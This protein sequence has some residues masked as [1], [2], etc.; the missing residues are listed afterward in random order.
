MWE[1][2]AFAGIAGVLPSLSA[3]GPLAV[4]EFVW[5]AG[6]AC[7]SVA[8]AWAL[9]TRALAALPLARAAIV[10]SAVRELQRLA[11]TALPSDVIPGTKGWIAA[12]VVMFAAAL[13]AGVSR[14]GR[15]SPAD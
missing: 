12:A 2:V 15:A 7:L 5:A 3:R 6:V 10:V 1:P 11:W 14:C 13:M 8:A 9:S 4:A